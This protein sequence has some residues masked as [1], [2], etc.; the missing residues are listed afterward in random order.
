[1]IF[2]IK[3]DIKHN[4][5]MIKYFKSYIAVIILVKKIYFKKDLGFVII[6]HHQHIRPCTISKIIGRV[7]RVPFPITAKETDEPNEL[8]N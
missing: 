8:R 7:I 3:I 4:H 6:F 2:Q 5:A 1:M